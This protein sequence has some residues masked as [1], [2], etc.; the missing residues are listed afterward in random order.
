M[1]VIL[2]LI[3]TLPGGVMADRLGVG[4]KGRVSFLE[5]RAGVD[6]MSGGQ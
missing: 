2:L 1:R 3:P 4:E 6:S 5:T